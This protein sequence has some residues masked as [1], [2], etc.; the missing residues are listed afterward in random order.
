MG[1]NMDM[2]KQILFNLLKTETQ[3][4][5]THSHMVVNTRLYETLFG[6]TVSA[7]SP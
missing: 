1:M 3:I 2:N 7:K 4:D 5:L 6:T